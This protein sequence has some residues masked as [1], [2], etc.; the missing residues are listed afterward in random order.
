MVTQFT[1]PNMTHQILIPWILAKSKCSCQYIEIQSN[2]QIQYSVLQVP[3]DHLNIKVLSHWHKDSPCKVISFYKR[4][5]Y[6]KET[7]SLYWD[8]AQAAISSS[9]AHSAPCSN[10]LVLIHVW[11]ETLDRDIKNSW[12]NQQRVLNILDSWYW[13][14]VGRQTR[15]L[16][17]GRHFFYKRYSVLTR[18]SNLETIEMFN[19]VT[20]IFIRKTGSQWIFQ[21]VLT[22]CFVYT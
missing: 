18:Q 3:G 8:G 15:K 22:K 4:N 6:N 11:W 12:S 17:L 13:H 5:P 14:H 21:L 19:W 1:N 9:H 2:W 10:H 7:Q 16:I 20:Q